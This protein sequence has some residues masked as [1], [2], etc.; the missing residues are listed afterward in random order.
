MSRI[1]R[2][3]LLLITGA[4]LLAPVFAL[5][6]QKIKVRRIGFL[7]ARSRSTPAKPDVDYDAFV[8]GMRELGY[9]EGNNLVIEWRFADGKYERFPALAAELVRANV[10]VIA[11][12]TTPATQALQRATSAIPIVAMGVG[13][14]VSSGLAANLARPGGNITGVSIVA[15]DLAPKHVELL[16]TLLPMLSRAA[17]L[18]N[19]GIPVHPTI[20]KNTQVAARRVGMEILPVDA[21]TAEEIERGFAKMIKEQVGA[22]IVAPDSLFILERKRIVELSARNRLP[23]I[24]SFGEDVRAGGLMSYGQNLAEHYRRAATLVDKILKGAK[25]AE[26]P[27][28]QPTRFYLTINRKTAQTL[29]ITIPQGL[30]LRADEVI[31]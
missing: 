26:L 5:A 29:G 17:F 9:V 13:D 2:R 14:P 30:A 21:R 16:K 8:D 28:E 11:C 3:E 12:N 19:S 24:S 6:Q 15:T 10:E 7:A 25:P 4:S 31:E 20:L 23:A 27:F 18:M 1:R 22:V